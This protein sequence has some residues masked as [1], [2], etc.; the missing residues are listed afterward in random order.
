MSSQQNSAKLKA[1]ATETHYPA[2]LDLFRDAPKGRI[3]DVP[4]GQGAFAQ[5]LL[6]AGYGDIDCLDINED[7]F[8]LRHPGV[9][10]TRHDVIHPLPFPD[11]HFDYVF[12]IEGIEHFD[13]P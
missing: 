13:N 9:R 6:K 1:M 10:F 4:A 7:A 8:L 5:E 2:V 11:G 3:L 12:S